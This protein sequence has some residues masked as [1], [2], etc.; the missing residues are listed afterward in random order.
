[1][2][3]NKHDKVLHKDFNSSQGRN[4][5]YEF[6]FQREHEEIANSDRLKRHSG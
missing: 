6:F 5:S 1:M 4:S 2:Y 3:N